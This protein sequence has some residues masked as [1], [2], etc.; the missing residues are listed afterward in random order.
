MKLRLAGLLLLSALVAA[1]VTACEKSSSV[2]G[3][4]SGVL[5]ATEKDMLA[6]LP[7]GGIGILGGNI[8][9]AQKWMETSPLSKMAAQIRPEKTAWNTCLAKEMSTFSMI[10]T[11]AMVDDAPVMRLFMKD[12]KI[13]MF[14][15]CATEAGL[16][17]KLDPDGK[18]FT[19]ELESAGNVTVQTPYLAV[20][21]GVYSQ[22]QLAG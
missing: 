7:K 9:Q 12:A 4:T 21:G 13:S 1:S 14:E 2:G 6:H 15:K 10:G 19:I 8:F 11:V 3:P 17:G 5:S 22:L 16:T 18:V 20:D